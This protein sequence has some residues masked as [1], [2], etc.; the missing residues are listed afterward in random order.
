MKKIIKE[1]ILDSFAYLNAGIWIAQVW[2]LDFSVYWHFQYSEIGGEHMNKQ[3]FNER[4]EKFVTVLRDLYLDEE[5]RE[6]AEIPQN[7][8]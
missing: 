3:E 4:V 6:G 8:T 5:E 2:Q 1:Y 7:R